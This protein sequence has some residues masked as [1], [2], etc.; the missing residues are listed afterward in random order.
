MIS[1]IHGHAG[2]KVAP[3]RRKHEPG[4]PEICIWLAEKPSGAHYDPELISLYV[5]DNNYLEMLEIEHPWIGERSLKLAAGPLMMSDRKEKHID[6]FLFGGEASIEVKFDC[7]IVNLSS[8]APILLRFEQQP[9]VTLLIEEANILL[10]RRRAYWAQAPE[11]MERRLAE[12]DPLK[13]Y[14]GFLISIEANFERLPATNDE[15]LVKAR[16]II[17]QE[18][19]ELHHALKGSELPLEMLC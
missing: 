19:D 7:T 17:R 2:F 9:E 3:A 15:V 16:H 8:P 6:G 10:A 1:S 4:H 14:A 13:L 11:E 18:L 5:L 12:H